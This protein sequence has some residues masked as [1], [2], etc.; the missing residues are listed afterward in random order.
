[1]R[2]CS[3]ADFRG[4]GLHLSR[5]ERGALHLGRKMLSLARCLCY[6]SFSAIIA[7]DVA[8]KPSILNL[9]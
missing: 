3:N 8:G 2:H 6:F 7:I 1:M 9:T 4:L 5:E